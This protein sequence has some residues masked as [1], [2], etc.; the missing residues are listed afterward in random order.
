MFD[1]M[2]SLYDVTL[3]RVATLLPTDESG[4]TDHLTHVPVH[5]IHLGLF[6]GTLDTTFIVVVVVVVVRVL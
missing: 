1:I 5:I 3:C 2:I 6:A 4:L